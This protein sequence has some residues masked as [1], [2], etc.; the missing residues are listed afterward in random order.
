MFA[1]IDRYAPVIATWPAYDR[2][3]VRQI[4]VDTLLQ[5]VRNCPE[6]AVLANAYLP[7]RYFTEHF[8]KLWPK[9]S[10]ETKDRFEAAIS[11][12]NSLLK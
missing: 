11:H 12:L 5:V 8:T 3:Q 4:A 7:A 10:D 1:L 2:W 6:P 9:V